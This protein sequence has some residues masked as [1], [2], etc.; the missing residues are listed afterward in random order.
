MPF[1]RQDLERQRQQMGGGD[2]ALGGKRQMQ[3]EMTV[4]K[5]LMRRNWKLRDSSP[6]FNP[7]SPQRLSHKAAGGMSGAGVLR[8]RKGARRR[9]LGVWARKKGRWVGVR[10]VRMRGESSRVKLTSTGGEKGAEV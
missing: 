5:V 8:V 1:R 6:L 4:R 7:P 10:A 9:E 3:R 2:Q